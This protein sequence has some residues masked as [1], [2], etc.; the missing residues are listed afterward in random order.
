LCLHHFTGKMELIPD[1]MVITPQSKTLPYKKMNGIHVSI[2]NGRRKLILDDITLFTYYWDPKTLPNPTVV[3]VGAAPGNHITLISHMFPQIASFILY[4]P[5]P[6]QIR[7]SK[8]VKILNQFF[9]DKDCEQYKDRKDIIF[10]SDIRGAKTPDMSIEQFE[11]EMLIP[12]MR[13]QENWYKLINPSLCCLKFRLPY[14]SEGKERKFSYLPGVILKQAWTNPESTETRLIPQDNK[15][16]DYDTLFYEQA[17]FYHNKVLR[18]EEQIFRN[19]LKGK[20]P[21]DPIDGKELLNDFD[22]VF[23]A[24]ILRDYL[25]KYQGDYKTD[26]VVALTRVLTEESNKKKKV[27]RSMAELR[28]LTYKETSAPE[29]SASKNVEIDLPVELN[30]CK[31]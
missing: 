2:E 18:G 14:Y 29:Q 1:L 5:S 24:I 21:L 28:A 26:Q 7:E 9:T 13:A 4:D 12:N 27:K 10:I 20:K 17:C 25:I 22:S 6:F 8:K 16:I 3:Y 19:P 31:R 30:A 11:K 15:N 23:E